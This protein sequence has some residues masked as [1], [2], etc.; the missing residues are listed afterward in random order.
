MSTRGRA[1]SGTDAIAAWRK[2]V[3][4]M[5][6]R[7]TLG[8]ERV[9]AT[10]GVDRSQRPASPPRRQAFAS[11]ALDPATVAR[12]QRTVGN[13]AVLE[14][15]RRGTPGA[16]RHQPVVGLGAGGVVQRE[17]TK[18]KRS[19]AKL[20]T[21][22]GQQ[23]LWV[24]RDRT[25]GLGGGVLVSDLADFKT[26]VM[27][28]S[29]KDGWTLVLAVHGSEDRL[30]A[31]APPDWQKNAVFYRAGDIEALF[32]KDEAFTKWRDEFGPTQLSLVSCQ[33]SASFEKTLITN[34][35]CPGDGGVRQ[36]GRAWVR[37]ATRFEGMGHR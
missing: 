16:G 27:G 12:L 32:G 21:G 28:T 3:P 22:G 11:A 2:M 19:P 37:A 24:V 34:L 25:I 30:G 33:V 4:V 23:Q 13:H 20:A 1:H 7:N 26:R 9:V 35:T 10:E 5:L 29:D 18:D 31:Q 15:L 14:A 8:P 17:K 36:P 6:Y